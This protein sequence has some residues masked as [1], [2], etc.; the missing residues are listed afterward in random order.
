M[1][2]K[3]REKGQQDAPKIT[4]L[5]AESSVRDHQGRFFASFFGGSPNSMGKTEGG[6]RQEGRLVKA[7]VSSLPQGYPGV[8]Q[9]QIT[10]SR[11]LLPCRLHCAEHLQEKNLERAEFYSLSLSLS[12]N[13]NPAACD[14]KT[15]G[16]LPEVPP[17]L[18]AQHRA[19]SFQEHRPRW[20]H[21]LCQAEFPH[22]G[23]HGSVI[24]PSNEAAISVE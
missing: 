8:Q 16:V 24:H 6:K 13:V 4:F 12:F 22:H 21:S 1:S 9:K 10:Q 11:A 17:A 23:C 7:I 19:G 14:A 2:C 5:A 3:G 20:L 15:G 18:G